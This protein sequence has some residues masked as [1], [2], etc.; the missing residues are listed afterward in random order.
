MNVRMQGIKVVGAPFDGSGYGQG[1]RSWLH[2]LVK[3]GIPLWI[4]PISFEKDR[5]DLNDSV[6]LPEGHTIV[7]K[8]LY[9]SL[10]RQPVPYDIN[11]VRLSPEVAVNFIDRSAI[12][13]CS[14]AWE[15]ED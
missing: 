8:D 5:P 6:V 2:G 15:T 7:E 14:C 11:F 10:C 3:A 4:Q 12:N 13:I 9:D 1:L